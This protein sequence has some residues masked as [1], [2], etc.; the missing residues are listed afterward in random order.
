MN[1]NI[2]VGKLDYTINK[3]IVMIMG[4]VFLATFLFLEMS[5]ISVPLV[6]SLTPAAL[7]ILL[8]ID[9]IVNERCS[10]VEIHNKKKKVIYNR[11]YLLGLIQIR[12]VI[13]Y[14]G[15]NMEDILGYY[16]SE[17]V[18]SIDCINDLVSAKVIFTRN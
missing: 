1:T 8:Y 5:N 6:I 11:T 15:N 2:Y 7:A 10:F 18:F 4:M 3:I 14:T 17:K 13:G 16:E 12:K 9:L